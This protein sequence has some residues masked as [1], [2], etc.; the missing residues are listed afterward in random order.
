MDNE[1]KELDKEISHLKKYCGCTEDGE[2][3]IAS[4][5]Y[6]KKLEEK[7]KKIQNKLENKAD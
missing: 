6:I 2:E 5:K 7:R 4:L 1:L 3:Y